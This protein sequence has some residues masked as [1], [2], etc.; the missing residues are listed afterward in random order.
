MARF[1]GE[2]GTPAE[3]EALPYLLRRAT[4]SMDRL[5]LQTL[6]GRGFADVGATGL[7]VLLLVRS[8]RPVSLLAESLGMTPQ[9]M[10]RV[11]KRMEARELVVRYEHPYDA[12]SLMVELTDDGADLASIVREALQDALHVVSDDLEGERLGQLVDDLAVV[13]EV[14]EDPH[15]WQRW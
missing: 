8:P 9:A 12:R 4:A 6:E 14:G 11:V 2:R 1:V 13:A 5:L 10:G 3:L 15:P 7:H